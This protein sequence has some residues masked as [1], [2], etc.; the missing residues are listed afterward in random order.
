MNYGFIGLGYLGSKLAINLINTGFSL[1]VY[2]KNSPILK[3]L[4]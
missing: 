4:N 2:D 1:T 3:F